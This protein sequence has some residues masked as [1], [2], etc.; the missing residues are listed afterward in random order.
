MFCSDELPSNAYLMSDG[1]LRLFKILWKV[2]A[3]EE[4][5]QDLS[6]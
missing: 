6:V 3:E 4:I 5:K 1:E 2:Y